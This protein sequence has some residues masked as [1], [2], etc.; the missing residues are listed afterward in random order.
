MF[1]FSVPR[2]ERVP[3]THP[4]MIFRRGMRMRMHMDMGSWKNRSTVNPL[5]IFNHGMG[6]LSPRP[7]TSE[8]HPSF[9]PSS[10]RKG[11][12]TSSSHSQ[13]V[14][15]GMHGHGHG[16]IDKGERLGMGLRRGK[17]M[18][19]SRQMKTSYIYRT[20][21]IASHTYTSHITHT[22]PHT[23][24]HTYPIPLL[25]T[26]GFEPPIYGTKNRCLAI[27]LCPIR[28]SHQG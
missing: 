25:G 11:L 27:R 18:K 13:S 28:L 14:V 21:Y 9:T 6:K 2:R 5:R 12:E 26:G 24:I 19:R 23:H 16:A 10:R 7:Y 20:T 1:T 8:D 17:E 22:T 3:E 15:E 4:E